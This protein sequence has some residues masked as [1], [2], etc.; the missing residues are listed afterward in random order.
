MEPTS[1][2]TFTHG[3]L[4]TFDVVC[5]DGA[6]RSFTAFGE[7]P[8]TEQE[9]SFGPAGGRRNRVDLSTLSRVFDRVL[10]GESAPAFAEALRDGLILA[11]VAVE[12][13]RSLDERYAATDRAAEP[14]AVPDGPTSGP[15]R[16]KTPP[17]EPEP[18]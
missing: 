17:P 6:T 13:F 1:L 10:V 5:T 18:A 11:P 12:V 15:K 4:V 8:F 16:P 3:P 14:A 9:E 7:P 2:G